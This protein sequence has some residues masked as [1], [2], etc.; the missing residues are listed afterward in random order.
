MKN[1]FLLLLLTGFLQVPQTQAKLKA[2]I[3]F[4]RA[5]KK[6]KV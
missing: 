1:F 6:A 4:M 5:K 2:A 3:I